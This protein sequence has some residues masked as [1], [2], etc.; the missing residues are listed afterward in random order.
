[1]EFY[2]LARYAKLAFGTP[3]IVIEHLGRYSHRVALSNTR[4]GDF[5]SD[6][7]VRPTTGPPEVDT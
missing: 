7:K 2:V 3:G 4:N 5:A 6:G 1:M